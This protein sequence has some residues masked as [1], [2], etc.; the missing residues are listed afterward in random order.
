MIN[1]FKK[2]EKKIQPTVRELTKQVKELEKKLE[3]ISKELAGFKKDMEKAIT[4]VG[5]VRFNPF[6]EIG[7]DQSFSTA[8]L[9][10]NNDGVVITSHYGRDFQRV[11]AKVVKGGKSEHALSQEEQEAIQKAIQ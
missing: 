11:Y 8:W 1:I 9:D 6:K 2:E 3:D 5:V 10:Q 4:K 7:G